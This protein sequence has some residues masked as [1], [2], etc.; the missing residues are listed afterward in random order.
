MITSKVQDY[1]SPVEQMIDILDKD[2]KRLSEE[3]ELFRSEI[4][5]IQDQVHASRLDNQR[6]YLNEASLKDKAT[7]VEK[8]CAQEVSQAKKAASDTEKRVAPEISDLKAQLSRL[9]EA[10]VQAEANQNAQSNRIALLREEVRI[11]NANATINERSLQDK[12]AKVTHLEGQIRI[13]PEH[14]RRLEAEQTAKLKE[15]EKA[16]KNI[17]ATKV[18]SDIPPEKVRPPTSYGT[19]PHNST[20]VVYCL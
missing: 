5:E 2:S 10:A 20:R 7:R 4:T 19:F 8:L 6:F 18:L 1:V 15:M 3:N 16:Q 14:I 13:W 17:M 12:T 9:K 11:L